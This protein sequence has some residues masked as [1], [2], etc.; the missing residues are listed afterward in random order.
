MHY[1]DE[2]KS[3]KRVYSQKKLLRTTFPDGTIICYKNATMT[4]VESL[5]KIGVEKLQNVHLDIY[6]R[7]IITREIYTGYEA[8]IKPLDNGWYV[9]ACGDSSE[10][11]IRLKSIVNQLGE[12]IVVEIGTNFETSN[13]KGFSKTKKKIGDLLVQFPDGEYIGG[14]SPKETYIQ[15]IIKIGIDT[16]Y[17]KG[18]EDHGQELVTRYNKYKGQVQSG[19]KWIT[20]PTQTKDKISALERISQKLDLKLK[21]T[22]I[23]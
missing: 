23:D 8:D 17:Y 20:I 1:E 21:M 22:I 14:I 12:D 6:K 7:P 15:T 2:D 16:I 19:D 4:F 5:R 9:F 3:G 11:F 13:I 10:K 18:F